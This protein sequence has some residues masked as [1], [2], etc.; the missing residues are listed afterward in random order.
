MA[1]C[2]MHKYNFDLEKIEQAINCKSYA[3]P[4]NLTF[5]EFIEW[6]KG[7]G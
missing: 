1:P 2:V 3:M 5:D 6:M 4:K 7:N